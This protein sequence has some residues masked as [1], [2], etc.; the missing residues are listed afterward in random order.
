MPLTQAHYLLM[1]AEDI[2]NRGD[3]LSEEMRQKGIVHAREV[4]ELSAL[5][6][7][8]RE[9][10]EVEKTKWARYA[11]ADL[12]QNKSPP[13]ELGQA[14]ITRDEERQRHQAPASLQGPPAHS[15]GGATD[16]AHHQ[17][18]GAQDRKI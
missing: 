11:A 15:A 8:A 2:S 16:G 3:E 13:N 1:L 18:Q 12:R 17:R 14:R 10:I 4:A 7:R 5:I 6:E 9:V